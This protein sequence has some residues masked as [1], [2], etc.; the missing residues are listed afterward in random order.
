VDGH[1]SVLCTMQGLE[2]QKLSIAT[3][4]ITKT[5]YDLLYQPVI[6][7]ISHPRLKAIAAPADKEVDTLLRV[8]D[9]LA[10]DIISASLKDE[11]AVADEVCALSINMIKA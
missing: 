8:L 4:S 9:R 1:G 10:V 2:I 3:R 6:N 7:H 11:P 5:R